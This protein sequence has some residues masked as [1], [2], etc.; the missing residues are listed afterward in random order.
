[1]NLKKSLAQL[2]RGWVPVEAKMPKKWWTN[3]V[4]ITIAVLVGFSFMVF[5]LLNSSI[6][7]LNGSSSIR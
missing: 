1:M 2:F 3:D 6:I 7:V 5:V 4:G